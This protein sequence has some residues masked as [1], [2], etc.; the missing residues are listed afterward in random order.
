VRIRTEV[1]T[2]ALERAG[3]LG[4]VR[5]ELPES[6]TTL[7]EDSRRV[8][9]GALFLAVRGSVADGHDY[10]EQ[11]AA[12]GASCVMVED[13]SRTSLPA[14]VIVDGR[15][16]AAV[17]A[18][19]AFGDPSGELVLAAVTGT[20]GKTTTV[21]I[22]RH[23]LDSPESRSASIG[24][25]GILVGAAGETMAGGEGLTTPAP[26]ELQRVLRALVDAGVRR[27]AMET[28]SHSLHQRRVDGLRFDAAVFTNFTRDHLDYHGSMESY[29][30]AKALLVD[31]IAPGGAAIINAD[32]PAWAELPSAARTIR[33]GAEAEADVRASDVCFHPRGSTW[34]LSFGAEQYEIALPLI[35]DFNV[36]NALGAAAAA[37]HLGVA[38]G[39]IADRLHRTPQVPGR[40][41]LLHQRPTVLRDYAH[42]PDALERVL[43]AVRPFA[44]RRMLV[45]FGCGGDRDRGKRPL[46]GA[47]AAR[48][49][50]LS[51]LTSDN[52]RNEDP[53]DI[54]NDIE[55]GMPAA[56]YERVEDRR[57]AIERALELAGGDDVIILAGK[58]HETYQI[59][60]GVK[61]PFDEK[62]V[63]Q[64]LVAEAGVKGEGRGWGR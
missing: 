40:L 24:T 53:E 62:E 26:V 52:P 44:S 41:E 20:N 61:Y 15:R 30:A 32:E 6:I 46:M 17:A 35:G 27:V 37:W 23:L 1:I 60:K 45:V 33:F 34:K 28:S 22:L 14:V 5:G 9:P 48:L 55:T 2:N 43:A 54:L 64:E 12:S 7:T 39:E 25:L 57:A 11:A 21:N 56:R 38:P 4:L 59:R 29:F 51:I 19:A 42:T 50:D 47:V 13:V 31:R 10:L 8:V 58:G 3:L 63:V 18:A 36:A 16:A 49:A